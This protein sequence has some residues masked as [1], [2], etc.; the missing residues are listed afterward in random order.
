[1][2]AFS[3]Q[4]VLKGTII[5]ASGNILV[6]LLRL[7]Q[8]TVIAFKFGASF[9]TDAFLVAQ[10]VPFFFRGVTQNA[11]GFSVVPVFIDLEK[12]KGER[13]AWLVADS[14]F[15]LT[16]VALLALGLLVLF[17]APVL[18]SV[19]APGFSEA[20]HSLATKLIRVMAPIILFVGLSAIP[21]ALFLSYRHFVM[22][23]L[24]SLFLGLGVISFTLLWAD[25]IGIMAVPLGAIAGISVE[26]IVLITFLA[27]KKRRLRICRAIA[28]PG[29]KQVAGLATP[30]LLGLSLARINLIVDRVFASSLGEGYI[31]ALT[32]A[33][34]IVQIPPM[35]LMSALGKAMLPTLSE[36]ASAGEIDNLRQR[37]WRSL[38]TVGFF[39]VPMTTVM[40]LLRRPIIQV[41][42]QRGAFDTAATALTG[43]AVLFYGLGM[44]AFSFNVI[45]RVFFWPC[46]TA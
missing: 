5:T 23:A 44:L 1:M 37:F 36:H 8:F 16:S 11:L 14:L 21:L 35:I 33:D 40:V 46:R 13:E 25:R 45:L 30:R 31:S 12:R 32:Y 6:V 20:T 18:T 15:T 24:T 42:F 39:V 10:T 38:S 43:A 26:F 19:L 34:R 28:T 41:F 9:V 27:R 7:L 29:V 2:K 22:P 17:L 4:G 3:T